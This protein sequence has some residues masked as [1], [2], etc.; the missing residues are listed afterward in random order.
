NRLDHPSAVPPQIVLQNTSVVDG[1]VFG[2]VEQCDPSMIVYEI[3]Q[4]IDL[5]EMVLSGELFLVS[6]CKLLETLRIM[7]PP[8]TQ[9]RA[10][11]LLFYPI[12]YLGAPCH[13]TPQ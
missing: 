2:C 10:W 4:L 9:I 8:C 11:R 3:N 12:I 7:V 6:V 13:E 1:L 5:F